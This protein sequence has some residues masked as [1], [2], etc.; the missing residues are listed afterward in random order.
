MRSARTPSSSSF[1]PRSL[2]PSPLFRLSSCADSLAFLRRRGG[3]G[4]HGWLCSLLFRLIL[5]SAPRYSGKFYLSEADLGLGRAA[6]CVS[7]LAELN[8]YVK[9]R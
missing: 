7:K 5:L 2:H 9:V 3:C 1:P 6:A 8:P 4:R